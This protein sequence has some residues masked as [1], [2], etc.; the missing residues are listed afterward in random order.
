V[1]TGRIGQ[2]GHM[3]ILRELTLPVVAVLTMAG[4]ASTV[5]GSGT[6]IAGP[7]GFPSQSSAPVSTPSLDPSQPVSPSTPAQST[8]SSSGSSG[9]SGFPSGDPTAGVLITDSAAH[10]QVRVL[11]DGERSVQHESTN[12]VDIT[13][14]LHIVRT[15]TAL[16]EA[17]TQT[18]DPALPNVDPAAILRGAVGGFA[19]SSGFTVGT[20]EAV[21]IQGKPAR[22]AIFTGIPGTTAQYT[23]V[24][25]QWSSTRTYVFFG[26]SGSAINN[27]IASF[28]AI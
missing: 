9:S 8:S 26:P 10:L 19:G 28:K 17:A 7:H 25:I 23:F 1:G 24:A 5:G 4:C 15:T 2:Y 6:S 12:G 3:R 21:T 27:M 22:K 11:A 14:Y 18:Y 20:Q 13:V 16:E